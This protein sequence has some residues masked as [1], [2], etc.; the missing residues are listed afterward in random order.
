MSEYTVKQKNQMK[1]TKRGIADL[2]EEEEKKADIRKK[3]YEAEEA[4]EQVEYKKQDTIS[5]KDKINI[6]KA[7]KLREILSTHVI[8]EN[9]TILASEPHIKLLIEGDMR[10]EFMSKLHEIVKRF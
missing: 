2:I 8:D 7:D 5:I 6:D 9:K 10:E 4:K 3:I 1:E